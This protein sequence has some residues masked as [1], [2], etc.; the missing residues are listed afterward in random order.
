MS[1][2]IYFETYKF[3]KKHACAAFVSIFHPLFA[4][5]HVNCFTIFRAPCHVELVSASHFIRKSVLHSVR[6]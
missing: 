6:I 1:H 4:P 2:C 3:V 5:C